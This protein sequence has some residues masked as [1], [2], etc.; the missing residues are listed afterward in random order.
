M[1]PDFYVDYHILTM[2]VL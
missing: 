2:I 1:T